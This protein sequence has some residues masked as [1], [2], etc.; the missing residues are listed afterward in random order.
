MHRPQSAKVSNIIVV[1][2][3]SPVASKSPY[4]IPFLKKKSKSNAICSKQGAST[5]KKDKIINTKIRPQTSLSRTVNPGTVCIEPLAL[6]GS[7]A[8]VP[9]ATATAPLTNSDNLP[10]DTVMVSILPEALL[11]LKASTI[12]N[13]K[14]TNK[15]PLLQ[16]TFGEQTKSGHFTS[17]IGNVAIW[18]RKPLEFTFKKGE[19]DAKAKSIVSMKVGTY[20][21]KTFKVMYSS[22]K[23]KTIQFGE[24]LLC[25]MKA[26]KTNAC[27]LRFTAK[28]LGPASPEKPLTPEAPPKR[29]LF[30]GNL[31]SQLSSIKN[32]LRPANRKVHPIVTLNDGPPEEQLIA[33]FDA[34]RVQ[35]EVNFSSIKLQLL[36]MIFIE[37]D[38]HHRCTE[39][40]SAFSDWRRAICCCEACTNC[41]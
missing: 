18:G 27:K 36:N 34:M 38:R 24:R 15:R 11:D 20:Q 16:I 9:M 30:G 5:L 19:F 14:R 29:F 28:K 33:A 37:N 17:C 4:A 35:V 41:R 6:Y 3:S 26:K 32:S 10:K 31:S 1:S 23:S 2:K 25:N 8:Q 7:T 39:H 40:T 13:W 22:E 12:A 21:N